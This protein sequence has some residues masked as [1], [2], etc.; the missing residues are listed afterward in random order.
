[1][2]A[3]PPQ[4]VSKLDEAD[5]VWRK[6]AREQGQSPFAT[7][8]EAGACGPADHKQKASCYPVTDVDSLLSRLPVRGSLAVCGSSVV[9]RPCAA[10]GRTIVFSKPGD[11]NLIRICLI[12]WQHRGVHAIISGHVALGDLACAGA[13]RA[14]ISLL[15]SERLQ[16]CKNGRAY[17]EA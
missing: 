13:F 11:A 3:L 5:Q 8:V 17:H 10:R 1:M 7:T 4:L 14:R 9:L 12:S 6:C 16:R 2:V 15:H